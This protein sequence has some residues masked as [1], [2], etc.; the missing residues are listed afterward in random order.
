MGSRLKD[1][2]KRVAIRFGSSLSSLFGSCGSAGVSILTYHRVAPRSTDTPPTWNVTPQHFRGQL[3][4]ILARGHR[5]ASVRDLLELHREGRPMPRGVFAVTFDDGYECVHH[6][7]WPILKNLGVPATVF[8]ATAYL[9]QETP[10]PFDDWS[11]AGSARVPAASWKPLTTAHCIEM[12]SEGLI[13]LGSHTHTHAV[14]RGRPEALRQDLALSVSVLRERF[15]VTAPTFA[16]PFGIAGPTLVEA[17]RQ[18]GV[19][20][21]LSTEPVMVHSSSDPFTWGRFT[22]DNSD[23]P[24]TIAARLDGWFSLARSLWARLKRPFSGR[25]LRPGQEAAG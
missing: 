15:G 21:S 3:E 2:G 19:V 12:S 25:G 20:C 4:G 24:A 13:E 11:E 17:A 7:A 16:F 9:D 23:T 14:F 6:H 1:L 18:A 8:L 22:V 10:F 5:P